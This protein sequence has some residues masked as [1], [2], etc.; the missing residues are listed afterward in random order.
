MSDNFHFDLTGVDL[1]RA[2]AIA[3][4]GASGGKAIGWAD[5]LFKPNGSGE[6]HRLVLFWTKHDAMT[7]LPAPMNAEE[8]ESFVKAWLGAADYGSQPDHDGDNSKGWRV[9]NEAWGH[10]AGMYQ[11]FVAIEP[12][13]L[14]YGK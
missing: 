7:A 2:L 14:M 12:T 6:R 3:F 9:Y 13:W 8:A 4:Q 5:L 11:A 1:K 10:V